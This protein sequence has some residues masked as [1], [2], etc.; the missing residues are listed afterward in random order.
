MRRVIFLTCLIG[1]VLSVLAHADPKGEKVYKGMLSAWGSIKSYSCNFSYNEDK[2]GKMQGGDYKYLFMKPNFI[3]LE[4]IAGENKATIVVYNPS[5]DKEKVNVKKVVLP[6]TLKRTDKRLEDFFKSDWGSDIADLKKHG[7]G[8][9]ITY[10]KSEKVS[11]R[12]ADV[13]EISGKGKPEFS[14]IVVWVDSQ[15]K[16]PLKIER[17]KS[18][19]LFSRREYSNV[20]VNAPLSQ[21]DFK[22]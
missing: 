18:K 12:T 13:I 11:G 4:G 19:T 6:L 3:R 15:H 22:I 8:A 20:K 7:A 5:K 9:S 2:N 14:K 10:K 21:D 1:A 16:V 17:F